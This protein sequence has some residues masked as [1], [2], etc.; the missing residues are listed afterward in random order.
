MKKCLR[1]IISGD[2]PESF[3]RDFV[4][5]HARELNLEGTGQF[6]DDGGVRVIVCG[7]KESV[8]VFLDLLHKG[9]KDITPDDISMEPF[10]RDKDY[11]GIFRVI[12]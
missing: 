9:T 3:L 8:D 7:N 6:L 2:Y 12:E 5:K 4:Q 11:R 10:V 1:I